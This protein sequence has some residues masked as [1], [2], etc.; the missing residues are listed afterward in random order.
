MRSNSAP[1]A[2]GEEEGLDCRQ[3]EGS[4]N[5]RPI[6]GRHNTEVVV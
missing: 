2:L 4:R 5:A 1:H 6:V 3:A